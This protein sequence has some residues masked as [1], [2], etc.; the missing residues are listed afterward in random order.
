M[1]NT[2]KTARGTSQHNE[3]MVKSPQFV[4]QEM[5]P[6]VLWGVNTPELFLTLG[7]AL[8]P[9]LRDLAARVCTVCL[10]SVWTIAEG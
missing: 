6:N 4:L 7:A 1:L 2:H 9:R 10:G 8:M 3:W 5:Q